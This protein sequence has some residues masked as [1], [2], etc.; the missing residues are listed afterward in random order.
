VFW[1]RSDLNE[2]ALRTLLITEARDRLA[3]RTDS[4]GRQA[5]ISARP[6]SSRAQYM[7]T[8]IATGK[9][10]ELRFPLEQVWEKTYDLRQL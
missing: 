7:A 2:S 8:V 4:E 3:K 10:L 6:A 1:E 5:A 9:K